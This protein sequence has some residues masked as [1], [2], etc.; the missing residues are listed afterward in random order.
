MIPI[1]ILCGCGQKYAFDVESTA[2]LIGLAVQ[3]PSCG[4]DGTVAANE[5]LAQYSTPQPVRT[6]GLQLRAQEAAPRSEIP[7][8]PRAD[9]APQHQ[10]NQ[11]RTRSFL[12]LL[13]AL[14]VVVLLV[15]GVV[16]GRKY[17]PRHSS[18]T[19]I[20]MANDGLPHTLDE[21][22][23]WYVEP[24]PGQNA[25]RF[26]EQ[27]IDA[28]QRADV[29]NL[30]VV[31]KGRMPSVGA[32]L[33]PSI[34]SSI[35]AFLHSNREALQFFDQAAAYQRCRYPADL[36]QGYD[37]ILP[38]M[39][40]LKEAM[41][42]VELSAILHADDR[43]GKQAGRDVLVG[44]AMSRS[45]VAEPVL[46][47]QFVRVSTA[48]IAVAALEQTLNR[49]SLPPEVLNDLAESFEQTGEFDSRGEPFNR[50][51]AAERINAMI[52][53]AAPDKFLEK[54]TGSGAQV[55]MSN[56]ERGQWVAALQNS[57]RIKDQQAYYEETFQQL[58]AARKA[59]FPERLKCDG[60]IHERIKD[61]TGRSMALATLLLHGL[62][63]R[64]PREAAC[65]AQFRLGLTAVA[66]EQFRVAHANHYPGSLSE[67]N[68]GQ[69]AA[70]SQLDPFDGESLRYQRKGSGY[71]LYSIGVDRRDDLG[72]RAKDIAFTVVNPP[73]P[74]GQ[75]TGSSVAGL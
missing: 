12:P 67:L 69:S 44:L 70:S 66:L 54:L 50:A 2:R 10:Q 23:A 75:G 53:L 41:S 52:V 16:V 25:A 9:F 31:G 32:P 33:P 34:K 13:A 8:P 65:V 5:V 18:G 38:Y 60:L 46:L 28:M 57:G 62:D 47:S 22:N 19:P 48:S 59:P 4:A 6:N 15:A 1:K 27:G 11:T 73:K 74:A 49:T 37:L 63:A 42:L 68:G 39:P 35:A 40:K 72:D 56:E 43:D 20:V 71:L 17:L 64:C 21:L 45:L 55:R 36:T 26:Y 14:V 7:L 61:A 58:M 24:P 30:P 29:P 51:L 3:C